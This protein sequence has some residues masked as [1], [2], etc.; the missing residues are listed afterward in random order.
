MVI[1][2]EVTTDVL[3]Y[4]WHKQMTKHMELFLEHIKVKSSMKCAFPD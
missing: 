4:I 1:V 2:Q 3:G